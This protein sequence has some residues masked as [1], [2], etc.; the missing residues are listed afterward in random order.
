MSSHILAVAFVFLMLQLSFFNR[1]QLKRLFPPAPEPPKI[2]AQ[3]PRP[4]RPPSPAASPRIVPSPSPL[5]SSLP[6]PSLGPVSSPAI[7]SPELAARAYI[8]VET[9]KG[10]RL[11]KNEFM[12]LPIASVAKLMTALVFK[13][14]FPNDSLLTVS[15]ENLKLNGGAP[16]LEEGD[17]FTKDEALAI[18]LV[19]SNNG[20]AQAMA[21]AVGEKD[22]LRLMQAR[23]SSIGMTQT[24]F[25]DASGLSD[26]TRSTPRDLA[27]MLEYLST[28][29]PEILV[30][31]RP[32]TLT[33]FAKSEKRYELKNT[34]ELLGTV[35]GIVGGKTGYT[36]A[37]GGCLVTVFEWRGR[38]FY[39]VVLGSPDRFE[40]MRK[41]IEYAWNL[42]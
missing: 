4:S 15:E 17:S 27:V 30:V 6:I 10:I 38:T 28:A 36:D 23:A 26:L 2:V 29:A 34:D 3:V 9:S 5:V 18:L 13:E 12:Y 14:N 1:W 11:A 35:Q 20:V 7:A 24:F 42:P 22:F 19:T 41:L 37:A 32:P 25:A 31:T 39:A 8:L 40:D 33:L 16:G 21:D